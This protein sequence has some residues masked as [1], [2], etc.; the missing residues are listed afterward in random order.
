VSL[1]RVVACPADTVLGTVAVL[2]HRL[3]GS[4]TSEGNTASRM[5][6]QVTATPVASDERATLLP[7]ARP[8]SD[9]MHPECCMFRNVSSY[10][11]R[12]QAICCKRCAC[13]SS[14]HGEQL[15]RDPRCSRLATHASI[16]FVRGM[17]NVRHVFKR[18][19]CFA[20]GQK[21]DAIGP[22]PGIHGIIRRPLHT[23][24]CARCRNLL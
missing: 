7:S 23:V 10:S 2:L 18:V 13:V 14:A 1:D 5:H 6:S 9:L 22:G 21:R 17:G 16:A 15:T 8:L 3:I 4:Y 11:R 24:S 19:R 20:L 12:Y